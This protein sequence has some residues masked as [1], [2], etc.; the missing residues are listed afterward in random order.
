MHV[1]DP[2]LLTIEHNYIHHNKINIQYR[3]AG[4]NLKR[5]L[6]IENNNIEYPDRASIE[7]MFGIV[8]ALHNYWGT[9]DGPW[10]RDAKVNFIQFFG[11]V[12][13]YAWS[14]RP[15]NYRR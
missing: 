15:W 9:Y 14:D 12:W 11:F 5:V 6:V 7:V 2:T 3:Q 8:I 4:F 10:V 13:P 1:V